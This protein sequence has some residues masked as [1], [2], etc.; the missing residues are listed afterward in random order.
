MTE[1][2]SIRIADMPDLGVVT[3]SSSVVGERAGSGRFSAPAFKNYLAGA[4][5]GNI[6]RNY[7]H[8]SMFAIQQRGPGPWTAAPGHTAD[9][10]LFVLVN[11]TVSWSVVGLSGTDRT[12]I[13]NE[14]ALYGLQN[15]F[16]G[17]AA[18]NSFNMLCQRIENA[19]RLGG[20]TITVSFWARAAAGAPRIGINM[21][22]SYGTGGTPSSGISALTTG[23]SV[24]LSTTMTR[25]TVTIAM[26]TTAGK[27]FG[28][29]IDSYSEL[30]FFYSC[31]ATGNANAGGIGVQSGTVI[32]WGV[33][34]EDGA[35]AT[36]TETP[37]PGYDLANCQRFYSTSGAFVAGYGL[38]NNTIGMSVYLP[39]AMHHVPTL[40]L[41]N[42]TST[43]TSAL[44]T[45]A[46]TTGA[47]VF[48]IVSAT[49]AWVIN[50]YIR[51]S[52]DL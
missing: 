35:I 52:A 13:G 46:S 34:L 12:A 17:N 47:T 8:N 41:F 9:R 19:L 51:F 42:N 7:L 48:G 26:P 10:W 11:D 29:N 39:V 23:A 28:S 49:G 18:D 38:I 4:G 24:T 37:D 27:T 43:N 15:V 14:A 44:S 30:R 22:V 20:K 40:Q 33:Q 50:T 6:G 36:P 25:Y 5:A 2:S 31:G 21:F 3:D 45:G 32:I 1:L 16:T